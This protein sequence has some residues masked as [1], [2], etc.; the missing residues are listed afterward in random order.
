MFTLVVLVLLVV[1]TTTTNKNNFLLFFVGAARPAGGR[2]GGGEDTNQSWHSSSYIVAAATLPIIVGRMLSSQQRAAKYKRKRR[3]TRQGRSVGSPTI[4]RTRKTMPGIFSELGPK[5]TRRMY[6]MTESSFWDL[7]DI[8]RPQMHVSK[9]RKRGSTPNGDITKDLRLAMALRYFCGGS[10]YDIGLAHGVYKNEVYKSVWEVVDAVNSSPALNL[11]FPSKHLDQ[12]AVACDF[13]KKSKIDLPNCVGA[14]DGILIWIHKPSTSDLKEMIGFGDRKFFCGR[15]KKFGLNMQG[16]CDARGVFMDVEIGFPGAASDFYAFQQ[17]TLRT[18]L[19][20]DGFLAPGLCLFGDN[21]YVNTPY[22]IVPFKTFHVGAKDDAFNF[23]HS[24]LRINIECAFGMLVH[25]W[26]ILRKAIPMG[27]KV[28]ETTSLVMCLCKLHNFCI[29][30]NDKIV[31]G[32]MRT[33]IASIS[34][35]GGISLPRLDGTLDE[36]WRYHT[37]LDRINAL[38]DGG[39]HYGDHRET[40]RNMI[41]HAEANN[42]CKHAR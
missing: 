27:I 38:M 12:M 10:P 28:K 15:K 31:L 8:I 30:R 13:Q 36:T 5:T 14:I 34:N 23:Y 21:A 24:S 40:R 22:M 1:V 7:L 39:E 11:S 2:G 16:V 33:D 29:H 17:S 41:R 26:G 4:P 20:T 19:E 6:R 35:E 3:R 37:V 18:K 42:V 9:K 25:R 32:Q